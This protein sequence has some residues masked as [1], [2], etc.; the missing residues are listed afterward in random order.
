MP[1]VVSRYSDR[2]DFRAIVFSSK[3]I[4]SISDVARM[5]G[6][7]LRRA[8]ADSQVARVKFRSK[9]CFLRSTDEIKRN[10]LKDANSDLYT[11]DVYIIS[12]KAKNDMSFMVAVPFSGMARE[13]FGK[14]HDKRP[15]QSFAYLRPKLGLLLDC[16]KQK[17]EGTESFH[18][19]GIN[20]AVSGDSGRADQVTVRGSDVVDSKIYEQ[21]IATQN[22]EALSLKKMQLRFGK[23]GE[24]ENVKLSFDQFGNY[25]VWVSAEGSNLPKVF[26]A[27]DILSKMKVMESDEEFPVRIRDD[28]PIMP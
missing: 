15:P 22:V 11:Y 1:A 27:L 16:L 20:W 4:Q 10:I 28:E 21:L 24:K 6:G 2:R 26:D 17:K 5:F 9:T 25:G 14:I 12:R 23:I 8:D 7:Q 3:K 19:T 18:S 13:V